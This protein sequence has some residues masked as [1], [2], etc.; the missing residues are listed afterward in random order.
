MRWQDFD[1]AEDGMVKIW[2]VDGWAIWAERAEE[3]L[4]KAPADYGVVLGVGKD[5][6]DYGVP[7]QIYVAFKTTVD[8]DLYNSGCV[9]MDED[10]E[11]EG[12]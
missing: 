5:D 11:D 7:G 10:D 1:T 6:E 8:R 4:A 2:S 9:G 3:A 12:K